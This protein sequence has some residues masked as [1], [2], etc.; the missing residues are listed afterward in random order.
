MFNCV[1]RATKPLAP[2]KENLY[3]IMV[4]SGII[5]IST[6]TN[7]HAQDAADKDKYQNCIDYFT[8]G[9]TRCHPRASTPL[10]V[11][12]V[13]VAVTPT[14]LP[15]PQQDAQVTQEDKVDEYLKN[16]GKP[17]R[18]FVEFY[19]N[20]TKEN[21]LKW[22]ATYQQM[23]QRGKALSQA[24][25]QADALYRASPTAISSSISQLPG[26]TGIPA[27][28]NEMAP[29]PVVATPVAAS[30]P[31]AEPSLGAFSQAS[32]M[33]DVE[34]GEQI[35][36]T[37]VIYYFSATCPFCKQ[38]TPELAKLL[39]SNNGKLKL[40][41]VDVTPLS[42]TYKPQPSNIP[43]N[44]TCNWRL[45][46]QEELADNSIQQTP[47]MLITRPFKPQFKLSGYVPL[48]QLSQFLFGRPT[49]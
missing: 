31:S 40:T 10:G 29:L 32:N 20:P 5:C 15:P 47:T 35:G 38:T 49:L 17:P 14:L 48:Q 45:P 24:W 41:C 33:G 3:E 36:A 43:N 8:V 21:A 18:E 2:F 46:T 28:A 37:N 13:Q 26:V 39:A 4:L 11:P 7:I 44:L 42:A 6:I 22:V 25:V 34:I 16:Y 12:P 27:Q 19:L 30:T 23:L 9:E 1:A